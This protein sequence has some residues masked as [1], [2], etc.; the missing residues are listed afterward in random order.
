M[1]QAHITYSGMDLDYRKANVLATTFAN[2]DADIAEP[3]MVAGMT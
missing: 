2:N 1:K 3:V